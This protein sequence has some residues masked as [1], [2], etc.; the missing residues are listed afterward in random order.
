MV[1][2]AETIHRRLP[3]IC[4]RVFNHFVRLALKG[5]NCVTFL[6]LSNKNGCYQFWFCHTFDFEKFKNQW[7]QT[8]VLLL[9]YLFLAVQKMMIE[10]YPKLILV[11]AHAIH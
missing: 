7:W 9:T 5:L 4:L 3:T 10:N 8:G 11:L 6:F 1:K 2:H